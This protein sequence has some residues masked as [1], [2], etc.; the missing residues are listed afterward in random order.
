LTRS[1]DVIDGTLPFNFRRLKLM[2]DPA[3]D[4]LADINGPS[5]SN[6]TGKAGTV[7]APIGTVYSSRWVALASPA[8]KDKLR[9]LN[10]LF[11]RMACSEAGVHAPTRAGIHGSIQYG[12]Y[13]IVMASGYEDNRDDGDLM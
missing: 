9:I 13:S 5:E 10:P 2:A 7:S 8:L 3:Y 1:F 6:P 4:G 11:I 12:A